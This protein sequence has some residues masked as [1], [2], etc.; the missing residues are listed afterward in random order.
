M[1][2]EKTLPSLIL[3]ILLIGYP[4]LSETIYTPSLPDIARS[5]NVSLNQV[6]ST[7]SIYFGGFGL[8]VLVWGI[9]ADQIG[10]RKSLLVGLGIAILGSL[11]CRSAQQIEV[12]LGFRF[13]Q[14]F[15]ASVGSVITQIIM[16]DCWTGT[17]RNQLYSTIGA[18][19]AAT[20]AFGP[21]LGGTIDEHFGWR[22]DFSLLILLA[23]ILW[24]LSFRS[25]PETR[26]EFTS[27]ASI[28]SV[29]SLF[30]QMM[31]DPQIL[32]SAL[33]IGA[34]NGIIFSYYGEAPFILIDLMQISPSQYGTTG[35]FIAV[36]TIIAS[37]I[38]HR[39]N[40]TWNPNRIAALG[41]ILCLSGSL[42]LKGSLIFTEGMPLSVRGIGFLMGIVWIFLGI[43]FII[44]NTLSQALNHYQPVVGT[45]SSLFGSLYY[46]MIAAFTGGMAKIHNGTDQAMPNYFLIL[47]ALLIYGTGSLHLL[48][49][50]SP[51]SSLI[52]LVYRRERTRT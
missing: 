9:L 47:S 38:S 48:R 19:L 32:K 37:S 46:V 6:E 13:L 30:I 15:G 16:R 31:K 5:L 2:S 35:I 44:P 40:T 23:A 20:P 27:K 11:G 45:A 3:L 36:A 51:I 49:R 1:S 22:A 26:P 39:L 24:L 4:Q 50:G 28:L 29:F 34:C 18:A 42:F 10:R 21:L 33:I 12:L 8:G 7:L 14:A 17:Q 41:S 25:L 52:Q 43:G